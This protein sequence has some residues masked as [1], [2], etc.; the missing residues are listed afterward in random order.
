MYIYYGYNKNKNKK[1]SKFSNKNLLKD[2][3]VIHKYF[4]LKKKEII[5]ETYALKDLYN[6]MILL[7]TNSYNFAKYLF[8]YI[9]IVLFREKKDIID[10]LFSE[11]DHKV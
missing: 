6:S 3:I 4:Y 11:S 8:F 10:T 7:T 9:K 1:I 5:G 2:K